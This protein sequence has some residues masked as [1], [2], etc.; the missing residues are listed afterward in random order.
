MESVTSVS[1]AARTI[2]GMPV[3]GPAAPEWKTLGAAL[4]IV[5]YSAS[6]VPPGVRST[7]LAVPL[8]WYGNCALICEG[9]TK[10]MGSTT[11]FAVR[12]ES[13]S[14][15]GRGTSMVARVSG[16]RWLPN[17]LTSPPGATGSVKSAALT[18]RSS[19]GGASEAP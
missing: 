4:R 11:P 16:L 12:Q 2:A 14:T 15:V 13:P 5:T 7:M 8:I 3:T 19:T 18:R 1:L 17:R 9:E 6:L 10:I